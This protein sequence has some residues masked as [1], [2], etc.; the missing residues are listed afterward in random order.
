MERCCWQDGNKMPTI[1]AQGSL[2]VEGRSLWKCR[3]ALCINHTHGWKTLE[4]GFALIHISGQQEELL[5]NPWS[6]HKNYQENASTFSLALLLFMLQGQK[7]E[8]KKTPTKATSKAGKHHL[9]SPALDFSIRKHKS[10]TA[11]VKVTLYTK[12]KHMTP[13]AHE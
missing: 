6:H 13:H 3:R 2:P 5:Q 12:S 9:S 8:L 7:T 11:A 4:P 10:G 1:P